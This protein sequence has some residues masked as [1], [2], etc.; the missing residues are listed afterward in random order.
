MTINH[1]LHAHVKYIDI[2]F[3]FVKEKTAN[4]YLLTW[5]LFSPQQVDD[6]LA[7]PLLEAQFQY[8]RSKLGVHSILHHSLRGHNNVYIQS[9]EEASNLCSLKDSKDFSFDKTS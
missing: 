8:L 5:Y 9:K 7:K 3:H 4:G 1:V 6:L 2:D